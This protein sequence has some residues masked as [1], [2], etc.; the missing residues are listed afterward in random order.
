[1][2]AFII[3][4]IISVLS[5]VFL[6][7][8]MRSKDKNKFLI[9]NSASN[10][11]GCISLLILGAYA[12]TVGP[13]V[14]TL[15]GLI[16]HHYNKIGKSQPK[17]ILGLYLLLNLLGGVITVQSL[18]GVLP[19]ISSSLACI[20][21]MSKDMKTSRKINLASSLLALP[22]LIVSKAYVSAII[23]GSSFINTLDAIRKLDY[24]K[25]ENISQ[26]VIADEPEEEH[27]EEQVEELDKEEV[28]PLEPTMNYTD[29]ITSIQKDTE[30][31][32]TRNKHYR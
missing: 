8:S 26:N 2:Q 11:L 1:M 24:K 13:I 17:A 29:E 7:K 32:L 30:M 27:V 31:K 22:Y 20:M 3:A 14:L 5:G 15:Q 10:L 25:D 4:Q 19:V 6:L 23:F 28:K 21:L 12:A 16:T 9:L 18:V